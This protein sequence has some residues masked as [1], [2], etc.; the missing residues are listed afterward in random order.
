MVTAKFQK[1][2][3]PWNKGKNGVQVSTRKGK[4]G[5]KHTDA[6]KEAVSLKMSKEKHPLWKGGLPKCLDCG[7]ELSNYNNKECS[8]C[9]RMTGKRNG[10]WK[11]GV[12]SIDKLCRSMPE[13][14]QWRSDCFQRDNWTC[15]TCGK[16]GYVTVHHIVGFSILIRYYEIKDTNEARKCSEL[17]DINNGVTLCEECHSLTDNYRGNHNKKLL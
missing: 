17:W 8:N 3:I 10:N 12:T 14:K 15:Q 2:M 9:C 11:E 4:V 13:Y 6:E 1:G 7:K 5:R 16:K